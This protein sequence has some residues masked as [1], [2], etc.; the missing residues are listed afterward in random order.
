MCRHP[1]FANGQDSC[2]SKTSKQEFTSVNRGNMEILQ[3]DLINMEGKRGKTCS[4]FHA[5]SFH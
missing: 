3:A 5:Y 1:E 4:L 2:P